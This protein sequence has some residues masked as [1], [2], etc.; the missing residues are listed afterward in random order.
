MAGSSRYIGEASH[1]R[2]IRKSLTANIAGRDGIFSGGERNEG[3][4]APYPEFPPALDFDVDDFIASAEYSNCLEKTLI[5]PKHPCG[6]LG[7][8]TGT[9]IST[10][11]NERPAPLPFGK[12]FETS[13]KC[14]QGVLSQLRFA[15]F[16]VYRRLFTVIF[17][18][19][20]IPL[21][22][23]LCHHPNRTNGLDM[24]ATAAS[25]NFLVAI[26]IRQDY[27]VNAIF[28]TAW[29]VLWSAPLG[30]RLWIARCCCYWGIHSGAVVAETIFWLNLSMFLTVQYV[31]RGSHALPV[32]ITTYL[33]LS[34]LLIILTLAYPSL[35]SRYHNLFELSHRFLGWAAIVLFWA[36]LLLTSM[37]WSALLNRPSFWN[38]AAITTFLVYPWVRLR[39]CAFASE[40]LSSHAVRLRFDGSIH[41][42]S[43]LSIS[44][45]PLREWHPFAAF[46]LFIPTLLSSVRPETGPAVSSP[47]RKLGT[48][49][50]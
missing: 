11:G 34:L 20:L 24:L 8:D 13:E 42:F 31:K 38:L 40:V 37:S 15:L 4:N 3:R 35:R 22:L 46:R 43:C 9:R 28:R 32:I 12:R 7:S 33:I 49:R 29:L 27:V 17:L 41:K 26:I 21:I 5:R 47:A 48:S 25:S 44:E 2:Q 19:N 45:A 18:A 14:H 16:T 30:T 23:L 50:S 10:S 36:Q 6:S 1:G 39:Q